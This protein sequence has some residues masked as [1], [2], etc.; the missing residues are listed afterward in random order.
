MI[1]TRF[2]Q[3]DLNR[4]YSYADYLLW[5]IQE[6]VELVMGRIH[7]MSPAPNMA[8]QRISGNLHG[9]L[10][11]FCKHGPCKVFAAPF[12]VRLPRPGEATADSIRT[13]VQPDLCVVCDPSRLDERGCHGAPDLVVEILSPGNSRWELREKFRL[14][15]ASGVP[16]Y[17]VVSPQNRNVIR[18]VLQP[19][20]QYLAAA[21]LTEPDAI[22]TPLFPGLSVPLEEVF[23]E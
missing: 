8:H 6:R 16:E 21:P 2:D 11:T 23:A 20:G 7:L 4:T 5:Q 12:D 19:E 10:W 15:E 3:L 9:L 22:E 1:I 13:V 18:Y 14:Y 17:W